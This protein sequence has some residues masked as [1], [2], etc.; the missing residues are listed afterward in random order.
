MSVPDHRTSLRAPGHEQEATDQGLASFAPDVDDRAAARAS[1]EIDFSAHAATNPLAAF[2]VAPVREAEHVRGPQRL[3][4]PL[5]PLASRP[6]YAMHAFAVVSLAAIAVLT[7]AALQSSRPHLTMP[8]E[9]TIQ[10]RPRIAD[11]SSSVSEQTRAGHVATLFSPTTARVVPP[12]NAVAKPIT[13]ESA[14]RRVPSTPKLPRQSVAAGVGAGAPKPASM[15]AAPR[16]VPTTGVTSLDSAAVASRIS[17]PVIEAPPINTLPAPAAPSP[18]AEPPVAASATPAPSV[19][20]VTQRAA[21][22]A[23]LGQYANAFSALDAG[24]AKAVWPTVNQKS[25]E[26]AFDS[27]EEQEFDLGT[28]DITVLAPR[29]LALCDGSARYVPKVG[30]RKARTESRRWSFSLRQTGEDWA[31]ESVNLR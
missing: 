25:L 19:R 12:L 2:A 16:P 18:A 27:L 11:S 29:A 22:E 4:M 10:S 28:C 30:N 5:P 7:L 8:I 17:T 23:V 24:R 6:R 1:R 9:E 3:A 26:R 13:A 21:V 20:V 15:P 14:A 31:I